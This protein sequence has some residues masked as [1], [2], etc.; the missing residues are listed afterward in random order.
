M[1][2]M[3]EPVTFAK[4][5]VKLL[6]AEVR[7]IVGRAL[8]R[9]ASFEQREAAMLAMSNEAVRIGLETELQAIAE[10]QGND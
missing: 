7:D 5:K 9:G 6:A 4:R 1:S 2:T 10:D 3:P 8:P